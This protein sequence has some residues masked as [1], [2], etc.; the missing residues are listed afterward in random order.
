[1]DS[2]IK[3]KIKRLKCDNCG[4]VKAINKLNDNRFY[5]PSCNR[6]LGWYKLKGDNY[7]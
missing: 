1:M 2:G 7:G 4:F 3:S 5:C 6:N